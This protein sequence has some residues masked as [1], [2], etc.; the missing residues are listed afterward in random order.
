[1]IIIFGLGMDS[2]MAR[3]ISAKKSTPGTSGTERTWAPAITAP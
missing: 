3:S 1:M 2:R